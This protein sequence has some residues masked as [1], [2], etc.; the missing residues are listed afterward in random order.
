M[1]VYDSDINGSTYPWEVDGGTSVAAAIFAGLIA[2]ADEVRALDGVPSLAG[3]TQTLPDLYALGLGSSASTYFNDI[4]SGGNGDPAVKGYDMSTGLGTP[5]TNL[6][7]ALGGAAGVVDGA[8]AMQA[9]TTTI[10]LSAL[11]LDTVVGSLKYS[12][13]VASQPAGANALITGPNNNTLASGTVDNTV[14]TINRVGTYTFNVTMTDSLGMSASSSVSITI[15]A[16]PSSI[17]IDPKTANLQAD[18]TRTFTATGTD[19]FGQ[20]MTPT[21]TWATTGLIGS[22]TQAGVLTTGW[23]TS[24]GTV[25][26]TAGLFQAVSDVTVTHTPPVVTSQAT[27]SPNPVTGLTA[28]LSVGVTYDGS[29]ASL[30]CTWVATTVPP[31]PPSPPTATAPM[32]PAR[33]APPSRSTTRGLTPSRSPFATGAEIRPPAAR[34]TWSSSRP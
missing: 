12:W 32:A 25:V 20:P 33:P 8:A 11:G 19:Q 6:V 27:A 4:T 34:A 3:P 2:D 14:A 26:A 13:T 29:P 9:S 5:T 17:G 30:T 31:A 18:Q 23:T 15:A 1:N 28:T 7:N 21:V 16:V 10:D 24:S 22:I